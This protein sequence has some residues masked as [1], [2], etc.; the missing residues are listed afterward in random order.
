MEIESFEGQKDNE[1]IIASWRQHPWVLF[2][3]SLVVILV[4]IIG[5]LPLAL[6]EVSWATKFLIFFIAVGGVYFALEL[7]L[8]LCTMYILTNERL[9]AISQ[10]R[11]LMRTIN[12]VPLR[13]IQ[14]VSH[15]KKGLFQMMLDYGSVEIQTA[16]S[17]TA[18]TLRNVERPYKVQQKILTREEGIRK[19][20]LG[21]ES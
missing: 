5:S 14:N 17:T 4:I 16:G 7:Y 19:Y 18:M 10:S 1:K 15:T 11:L 8:W 13:N 2:K 6:S 20:E 3:P 12:E 21:K 9:L